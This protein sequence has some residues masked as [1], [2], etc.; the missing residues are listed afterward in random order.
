MDIQIEYQTFHHQVQVN[1]VGQTKMA[2]SQ[3]QSCP[4][5]FVA[6]QVSD[7]ELKAGSSTLEGI[8][9]GHLIPPFV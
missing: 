7:L 6:R 9:F 5:Y 2:S 8:F 1:A 4:G 3:A